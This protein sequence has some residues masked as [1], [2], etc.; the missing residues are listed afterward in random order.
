MKTFWLTITLNSDTAFGRGDGLAGVVNSEIQHDEN[1]LP[2]LSG[3]TLKGLLTSACAE[4]MSALDG[5]LQ[6]NKIGI[7]QISAQHLFGSPGSL[8]QNVGWMH[9]GDAHCPDDLRQLIAWEIQQGG[10]SKESVLDALTVIRTQ[11]AINPRTG[12]PQKESLRSARM[13]RQGLTLIARLDFLNH[14]PEEKDIA[15]LSA[16]V[17][18]LKRAGSFRN[19]GAGEIHVDLYNQPPV[20]NEV[21]SITS[22]CFAE[23]AAEVRK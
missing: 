4:I 10:L 14:D 7:W 17:C 20:M 2:Y 15:L 16:S 3:K 6:T 5:A 23:F 18:A 12:A 22:E 19:R 11:T 8:L 21:Q 9:I 13:I 1:G